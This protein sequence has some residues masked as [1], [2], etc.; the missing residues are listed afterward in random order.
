MKK[1]FLPAIFILSALLGGCS[2]E[3]E[4]DAVVIN[5][6]E[7]YKV[8]ISFDLTVSPATSNTRASRPLESSDCWQRVTDVKIYVFRS[9]TGDDGSYYYYY[10]TVYNSLTDQ[11]S[12]QP[13]FSVEEFSH[14]DDTN[15][16]DH[17]S[18]N[19][20][21]TYNI[22]PLLGKGYYRF[23]AVGRDDDP[24][25]TPLSISWRQ[26]ITEWSQALMENNAGHPRVT[27]IFSGY[28]TEKGS[29]DVKTFVV[30]EKT[31][32][33]DTIILHRAVAGVLLHVK[34]IP[35]SLKS[36]FSWY[37]ID[38]PTGIIRQDLEKGQEYAVNEVAIVCA[39]YYPT[40][41]LVSR[42]WHEP[43][44]FQPDASRFFATRL[45]SIST[46][47]LTQKIGNYGYPVYYGSKATGNFVFPAK[48]VDRVFYA[49]YYGGEK[50]D[51]ENLTAF[52]RSLYLCFY[53]ISRTGAYYP[54][55]MIPIKIA[56]S[57]I[58]DPGA[59]ENCAGDDVI[60]PT[61]THFN[62]VANHIYCLGMKNYGDDTDIPI[63]LEDQ[64][65]HPELEITVVGAWQVDIDIDMDF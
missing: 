6:E 22:T 64:L 27:E 30:T 11:T 41:D 18:G 53:T 55:K 4:P 60:D 3:Q 39:G 15:W 43:K 65:S 10:P 45:A 9:D 34:N 5:G 47:G 52:D 59:H 21:H 36:D 25:S 31:N 13:Y 44:P 51:P 49:D 48:L 42:R 61:G 2:A 58:H 24:A 62:L 46:K 19:E 29:A 14:K 57:F 37:S 17:I 35:V 54:I 16:D 50:E 40:L 7:L 20:T 12:R 28:P 32:F 1:I 23:L 26:N 56:R 33:S 8:N 38:S 63:D